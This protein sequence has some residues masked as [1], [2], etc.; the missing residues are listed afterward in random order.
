MFFHPSIRPPVHNPYANNISH[1]SRELYVLSCA[2][3]L[4][5][6]LFLFPLSP[7]PSSSTLFVIYLFSIKVVVIKWWDLIFIF[8]LLLLAKIIEA[9]DD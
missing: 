1:I 4:L 5:I 2:L 3:L 8:F 9:D 7:F 6:P